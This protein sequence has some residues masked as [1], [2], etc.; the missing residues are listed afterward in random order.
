MGMATRVFDNVSI[1]VIKHH[2][3][4]QL[5]AGKRVFFFSFF[6]LCF[7]VMIYHQRKS[8]QELKAGT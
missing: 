4:R 7:H 2:D 3:Q 6:F 8:E 5:N 1:A